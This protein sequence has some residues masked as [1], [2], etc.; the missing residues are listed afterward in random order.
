MFLDFKSKEKN[1]MGTQAKKPI[2]NKRGNQAALRFCSAYSVQFPPG[3]AVCIG[4]IISQELRTRMFVS[5]SHLGCGI[6]VSAACSPGFVFILV[7]SSSSI[8]AAGA[9][10]TW[11]SP[12]SLKR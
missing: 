12:F 2:T 6:S 8:Q 7:F 10:P 1:S 9:A 3:D 4:T 5:C 11:E